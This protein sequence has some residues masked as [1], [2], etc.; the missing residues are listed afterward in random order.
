M[1][2]LSTADDGSD[3]VGFTNFAAAIKQQTRDDANVKGNVGH[4]P[5]ALSQ[6]VTRRTMASRRPAAPRRRR[7]SR[8]STRAWRAT[9]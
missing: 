1:V 9:P 6:L 4:R 3:P 5:N 2:S 7:S 8:C